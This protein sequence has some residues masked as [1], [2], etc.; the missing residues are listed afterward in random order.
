MGPLPLASAPPSAQFYLLVHTC[1]Y[2]T[3]CDYFWTPT[4]VFTVTIP[5]IIY[6]NSTDRHSLVDMRASLLE[7]TRPIACLMRTI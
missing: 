2:T 5:V 6:N 3:G 4:N 1:S 7:A